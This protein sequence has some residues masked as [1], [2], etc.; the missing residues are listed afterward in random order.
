MNR[1]QAAKKE[2]ELVINTYYIF[3]QKLGGKNVS[4]KKYSIPHEAHN[5][6]D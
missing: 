5:L 1:L 2:K 3:F 6:V 4:H